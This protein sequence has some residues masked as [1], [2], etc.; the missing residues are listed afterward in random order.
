MYR[1]LLLFLTLGV[2]INW[3]QAQ[4]P[5]PQDSTRRLEIL[6]AA[7]YNFEKK[8]SVTSLLCLAGNV[9]LRQQ[10]TLFFADSAVLNQNTNV[11]EAFGNIHINDG[12][13]LHTYSK[14]LRYRRNEKLA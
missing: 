6:Q 11:V 10:G 1:S 5:A 12:D 4:T 2:C 8:D 3:L 13:S 14:Y 7:G 9:R